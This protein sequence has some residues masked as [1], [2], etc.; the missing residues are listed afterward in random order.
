MFI[1]C[2]KCKY[3]DHCIVDIHNLNFWLAGVFFGWLIIYL[4]SMHRIL[5]HSL[6]SSQIWSFVLSLEI[7]VTVLPLPWWMDLAGFVS[8]MNRSER[9]YIFS[10]TQAGFFVFYSRLHLFCSFYLLDHCLRKF[11]SHIM[12][13]YGRSQTSYFETQ[14]PVDPPNIIWAREKDVIS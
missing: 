1:Y 11:Q 6:K 9:R 12:Q 2:P 5:A 14:K 10:F 8:M 13:I 3:P 4:L 7:F